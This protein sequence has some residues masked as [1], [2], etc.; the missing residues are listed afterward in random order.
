MTVKRLFDL[1][2]SALVLVGALPL[3][4][5]IAL[6]VKLDSPGPILYRGRRIGRGGKEFRILKFRT[7]VEDAEKKGPPVTYQ[8]DSRITRIG[9]TLRQTKMDEL[10]QLLNVLKGEM[11]LVG[12]RAEDPKYRDLFQGR[13]G[14][15]L[16]VP[17]GMTGLSWVTLK[18]F[19][20]EN[21]DGG[22]EWER[23]YV[24]I[25]LP[26]KLEADLQYVCSRSLWLDLK[27][28]TRTLSGFLRDRTDREE[29]V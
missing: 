28:L 3:M 19:H 8:G 25:S 21:I 17:P 12:P 26:R 6:L 2:A 27:I 22:P 4:A 15:L 13:Y 29:Q 5:T 11:S 10:P 18:R 23:H 1:L 9:R 16:D 14:R 20:E 7:M 24:E